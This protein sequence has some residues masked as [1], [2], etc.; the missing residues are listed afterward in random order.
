VAI[1]Y[2]ER[3]R[4]D[5]GRLEAIG[6]LSAVVKYDLDSFGDREVRIGDKLEDDRLRI[7][8]RRATRDAVDRRRPVDHAVE[9]GRR[10]RRERD[11]RHDSGS[12][13]HPFVSAVGQ[14][15][16]AVRASM[17]PSLASTPPATDRS[18]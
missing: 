15:V 4:L 6:G 10:R 1:E 14:N 7:A 11:L 18:L 2:R 13:L 5:A 3:R 8:V 9:R 17:A 16:G 12:H